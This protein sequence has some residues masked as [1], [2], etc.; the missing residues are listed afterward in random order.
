[1]RKLVVNEFL[2]LDDVRQAPGNPDE[3]GEAASPSA[4]GSLLQGTLMCLK[5]SSLGGGELFRKTSLEEGFTRW[6]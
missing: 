3:D 1:M 6:G 5:R 2:S 4:G